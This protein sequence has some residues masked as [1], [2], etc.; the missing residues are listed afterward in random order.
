MEALKSVDHALKIDKN[1][2]YA[3]NI[4]GMIHKSNKESDE[5]LDCFNKALAMDNNLS[6]S[7]TNKGL[8]LKDNKQISESQNLG[9]GH[10]Y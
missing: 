3:W 5:A 6:D 7:W 4:K 9:K 2:P 8:I 10:F 1:N